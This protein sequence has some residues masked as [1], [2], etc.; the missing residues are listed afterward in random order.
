MSKSK[1]IN[2]CLCLHNI[3]SFTQIIHC[4]PNV[5]STHYTQTTFNQ[6]SWHGL[7]R[8]SRNYNHRHNQRSQS[9]NRG[10]VLSRAD[11][12]GGQT[13]CASCAMGNKLS[14]SCAPLIRGK[15]YRYED[16]PWQASRRRDGH[17]LRYF[18]ILS[19]HHLHSS[20]FNHLY[21]VDYGQKC[22]T[23]QPAGQVLSNGSR[24]QR[25]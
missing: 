12:T 22:F 2:I 3:H 9:L 15:G 10:Q 13:G 17:L 20:P 18:K 5:L 23:C 14:C 16:S 25:I 21:L 7:Q 19:V 11:V 1:C 24:F 4:M 6:I 8:G